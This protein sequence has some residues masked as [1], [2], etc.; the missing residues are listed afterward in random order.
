M[1][2][3]TD[4]KVRQ[5]Y[6]RDFRHNLEKFEFEVRKMIR[7]PPKWFPTWLWQQLQRYFLNL[8]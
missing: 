3:K 8:D 6:R 4:K 5:L 2:G 1:S 7:R